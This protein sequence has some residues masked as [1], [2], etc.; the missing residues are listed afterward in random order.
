VSLQAKGHGIR[1][2]ARALGISR[3]TVRTVLKAG[4]PT[5]P[6][7][8]R[9]EQAEPHRDQIGELYQQCRGNLVRV[10]EELVAAGDFL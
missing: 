3:G 9:A 2:I 1:Q 7:L 4:T 5:V 8:E 6:R 10:P